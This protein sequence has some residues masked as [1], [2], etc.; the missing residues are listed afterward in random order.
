M[1]ITTE[2]DMNKDKLTKIPWATVLEGVKSGVKLT[3]IVD[4]LELPEEAIETI[5]GVLTCL[6]V[7]HKI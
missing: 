5:E 4:E 7:L 6:K 3:D 2:N 1:T